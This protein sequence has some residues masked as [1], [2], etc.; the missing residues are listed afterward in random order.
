MRSIIMGTGQ[1]SG[2]L[3]A[4]GKL[5]ANLEAMRLGEGSASPLISKLSFHTYNKVFAPNRTA[6]DWLSVNEDNVDW[7]ISH[8]LCGG[9]PTTGLFRE[10][11]DGIAFMKK[12]ENVAKMAKKMP[13]LFISGAMDPVGDCSKGVKLAFESF[14]RAGMQD[15]S[16]QLYPGLRHE[17]LCETNRQEIFDDILVWLES[18]LLLTQ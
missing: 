6:F 7:Y 17:I 1:M 15:I 13:I 3:V 5:V 11:L 14:R 9:N 2:L 4:G 18:K 10:M 16:L 8:P 12:P